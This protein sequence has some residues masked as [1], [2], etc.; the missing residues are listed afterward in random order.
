V[1]APGAYWVEVG[2]ERGR[3]A[4]GDDFAAELVGEAVGEV[5]EHGDGDED[6]VAWRPGI[7]GEVEQAELEREVVALVGDGGVDS[8]GVKIEVMKLGWVKNCNSSISGCAELEDS[9]GAVGGDEAGAEDFGECAGGVSA[10]GFHLP[11]AVLRGDEALRDDEVVD[12][13]GVDVGDAVT[14][15]LDGDGRGEAG[16]GN[17]AI[18]LR[19]G[20]AHHA[21]SPTACAEESYDEEDYYNYEG[22][23]EIAGEVGWLD[24]AFVQIILSV[25]CVF[26]CRRGGVAVEQL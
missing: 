12:G 6:G 2:D 22:D 9:L 19:K 11:E 7:G 25:I 5:L 10:K 8:A 23:G 4:G 3:E 1:V 13:G 26:V 18:E 14:I 17:V 15:A 21:M 16:D 20:V 24:G